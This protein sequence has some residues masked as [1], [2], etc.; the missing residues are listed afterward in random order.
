MSAYKDFLDKY[1]SDNKISSGDIR[2]FGEAGGSQ[3][4]AEKFISKAESGAKGYEG[5]VGDKAYVAADKAKNFGDYSKSSGPSDFGGGEI[6][7]VVEDDGTAYL[8]QFYGDLGPGMT[9]AMFDQL[10]A[11]SL[12]T[13]KGQQNVNYANAVGANSILVQQLISD[14]NDYAAQ[15]GLQGTQYAS[16]RNLDIAQYTS[17][18]E[19]RWRKYLADVGKESAAEVQGLKNQ[20]AVDLQ[21]IVNTGLTDV[22]DIQGTYASERVELQGEYDVQRANIQSD[23]EKFKAARAKEGQIYGSLMAGFWS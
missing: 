1:A 19:E 17:D 22:A 13:I 15:L 4:D 14:S 20:G 21:A 11:E 7:N 3:A 8:T 5:V 16:D 2:A 9:P 6:T 18:S 12:E 23:F 10:G